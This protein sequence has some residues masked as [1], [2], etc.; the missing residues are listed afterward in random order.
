MGKDSSAQSSTLYSRGIVILSIILAC[1]LAVSTFYINYWPTDSEN[2]YLPTASQLFKLKY[3]SEIHTIPIPGILRV[4][5]HGKESLILGIAIMQNIFHD[6]K[7]LFPNVFLL[8]L[9]VMSSSILVYFISRRWL[10]EQSAIVTYLLFIFCFWPYQYIL[11]GAHQPLALMFFLLAVFCLPESNKFRWRYVFSGAFLSFMFFSSPT[12]SLLLIYYL[13]FFLWNEYNRHTHRWNLKNLML[14]VICSLVG[15]V[16]IFLFFTLPDPI[17]TIKGYIEFIQ[18]SKNGNNL[19]IYHNLLQQFS[20]VPFDYRGAGWPWVFKYFLLIMPILFPIYAFCLVYALFLARRKKY[21]Y[22]LIILSINTPILVEIIRVAQFGRNY[23]PWIVGIIGFLGFS[24]HY[25]KT[26]LFAQKPIQKKFFTITVFAILLLHMIWNIFTF[27]TDVLQPRMATT[28]IYDWCRKNNINELH[29][30]AQHPLYKNIMDSLNNHKRTE[31]I[32]FKHIHDISEVKEGYIL[33]P[34]TTGKT[35]YVECRYD[36]YDRDL[37]LTRLLLSGR[38]SEFSVASFKTVAA[39][40]MW[41]ME[42]EICTFRDLILGQI[43]EADRQQGYA[44]ILD[45]KKLHK[46]LQETAK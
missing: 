9:A 2:P 22:G 31:K 17:K 37:Y 35:I 41:N 34:P 28:T 20:P 1:L 13:G 16:V 46:F 11:L 27:Y 24:F 23:F 43:K 8:I 3:I 21:L 36:N 29:V 14:S 7:S 30:Y 33:I 26:K 42:E 10:D 39:S 44:H 25:A 45:A 15:F 18:F 4:N 32:R 6:Y 5:M 12:S 40:R 19:I 38:L